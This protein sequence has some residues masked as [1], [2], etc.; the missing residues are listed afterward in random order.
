M[1]NNVEVYTKVKAEISDV[2]FEPAE[3]R[4]RERVGGSNTMK[5]AQSRA[6]CGMSVN[7]NWLMLAL[8][9]RV[10]L[11]KEKCHCQWSTKVQISELETAAPEQAAESHPVSPQKVILCI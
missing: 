4:Q 10:K 8:V 7:I 5:G 9:G 3:R 1:I 2:S 11:V 6:P